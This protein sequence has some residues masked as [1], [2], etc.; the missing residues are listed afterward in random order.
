MTRITEPTIE[1]KMMN[2]QDILQAIEA[3]QM[4]QQRNHP[5]SAKWQE[6]S[7]NLH[8]LVGMLRKSEAL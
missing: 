4:I 2:K 3:C 8:I 7:D 5:R 6:A 1:E